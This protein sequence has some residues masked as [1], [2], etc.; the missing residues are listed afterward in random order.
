MIGQ[1]YVANDSHQAR[2][3]AKAMRASLIFSSTSHSINV[4]KVLLIPIPTPLPPRLTTPSS[5]RRRSSRSSSPKHSTSNAR[6]PKSK[7]SASPYSST[8]PSCR[9]HCVVAMTRE[10]D[11]GGGLMICKRAMA[12]NVAIWARVWVTFRKRSEG[13]ACAFRTGKGRPGKGTAG[14]C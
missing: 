11:K 2:R 10:S 4:Q 12:G 3:F 5:L 8:N 13:K 6:F 14:R 7:T 9:G 1:G